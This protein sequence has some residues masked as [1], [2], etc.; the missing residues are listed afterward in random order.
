MPIIHVY[1]WKG[2]SD[3]A[4]RKIIAGITKVFTDMGIPKEAVEVI[5]HEI[6][7]ESWGVG[8]E[9]ASEKLRDFRPP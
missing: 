5:I 8:G 1:G 2:L 6:P 4:K 7:K 3:E 9:L